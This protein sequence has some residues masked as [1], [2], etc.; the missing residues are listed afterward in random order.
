M[1]SIHLCITPQQSRC[2]AMT[3]YTKKVKYNDE[4]L[5]FTQHNAVFFSEL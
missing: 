2:Y 1:K 4:N 5:L 3:Q